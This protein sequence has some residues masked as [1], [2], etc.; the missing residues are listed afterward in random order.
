MKL[1]K[2]YCLIQNLEKK[3]MIENSLYST[4]EEL[5]ARCTKQNQPNLTLFS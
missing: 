2:K 1:H 4:K 3:K 5:K